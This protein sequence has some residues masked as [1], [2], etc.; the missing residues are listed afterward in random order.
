M[1]PAGYWA[2]KDVAGGK[3]LADEAPKLLAAGSQPFS[4]GIWVKPKGFRPGDFG[5]FFSF[6]AA[7][8]SR[9]I[10]VCLDGYTAQ[11]QVVVG[12]FNRN[13][14][15]SKTSLVSNEWNHVGVSFDGV[16]LRLFVNGKPDGEV[17]DKVEIAPK[18]L[19]LGSLINR[20][21]R[22]EEDYRNRPHIWHEFNQTYVGPLPDV[23]VEKKLAGGVMSQEANL[24]ERHRARL[25]S[26][27]LLDRYASLRQTSIESYQDY[28]KQAFEAA[29]QMPNLDGYHWWVV[30]EI[31]AGFEC[32][33]TGTGVL[34]MVY[35]PEK[36]PD[37]KIF[38][39][40]NSASVLLI[41]ADIDQRVLTS[42]EPKTIVISLSHYGAVPVKDG[43]L[44]WQL[45]DTGQVLQQGAAEGVTAELGEVAKIGSI[46]L[47]PLKATSAKE[48]TLEVQLKSAAGTQSNAWK[49]WVF[50]KQKQSFEGH[51]IVNLTSVKELDSRY[52]TG[53]K[54]NLSGAKLCL[55]EKMTPELLDYVEQGGSLILLER[56][57]AASARSRQVT[58]SHVDKP[59]ENAS[60]IL[61]ESVGLP[62]WPRWIRSNGNFID[63]HP[64]L[65]EFPHDDRPDY[66]MARLFGACVNAVDFSTAD[67]IPRRKMQPLLW[68]LNLEE[69]KTP[70][71]NFPA[72]QEFFYG[73]MITEAGLGKGKI[74]ICSL[75][76]LDG[77]KRGYPE[78]GFLLDC[79]VDYQLK[80]HADTRLPA[81]TREEANN[82]FQLK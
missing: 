62:F 25:A 57:E 1:N 31:P 27:G 24:M 81:L 9:A 45:K 3:D 68:G 48:L 47:S 43:H 23:Y 55:A 59:P 17:A 34:D 11:G 56:D 61:R 35:H 60:R 40:F 69:T 44:S 52:A 67:S 12:R 70:V 65:Q 16:K 33:I 63:S 78:A 42:D 5:T 6:G 54:T 71:L 49:F 26:L 21:V 72:P 13:V 36:F 82:L 19:K 39:P 29:R 30:S 76:A 41:D 10:L 51:A 18:D 7:E 46:E 14:L 58:A 74:I 53:G 79:L 37:P 38:L 73:S 4:A 22:S 66:Q 80:E 75:W 64:A 8:E 28:V 2:G 32:D 50:P 77:I 15:T 20:P